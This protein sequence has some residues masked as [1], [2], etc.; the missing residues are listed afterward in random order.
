MNFD[1]NL[2]QFG[3]YRKALEWFDLVV[4]DLA[5]LAKNP[6]M[7]RLIGQQIAS[8][9]SVA[10]NIEEGYGLGSSKEYCQFLFIARGSAQESVGRYSRLRHWLPVETIEARVALCN[11]IIAILSASIR[12]LRSKR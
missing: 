4:N 7:S 5:P 12:T 11:D 10:S 3:A 2:L 8:V 6:M 1:G 9:D